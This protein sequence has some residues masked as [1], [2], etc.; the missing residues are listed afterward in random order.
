MKATTAKLMEWLIPLAV[1]SCNRFQ[2]SRGGR[3]AH[4]RIHH[5]QFGGELFEFG[6]Q[7]LEAAKRQSRRARNMSKT[8]KW[9]GAPWVGFGNKDND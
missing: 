1:K 7:V 9:H 4:Y 5:T 6:E 3:A 2:V 8:P